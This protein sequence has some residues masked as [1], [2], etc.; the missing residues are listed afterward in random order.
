MRCAV[1]IV[2]WI[3]C[4]VSPAHPT[5]T[6]RRFHTHFDWND[7]RLATSFK[8]DRSGKN[9]EPKSRTEI[10]DR[11]QCPWVTSAHIQDS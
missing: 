5:S 10:F 8:L 7:Q 6:R 3:I 9:L 11:I 1:F 4:A 2:T